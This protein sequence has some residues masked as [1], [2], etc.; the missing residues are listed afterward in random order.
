MGFAA[1]A[2]ITGNFVI[3]AKRVGIDASNHF[4]HLAG[5]HLGMLFITGEIAR[6][7]AIHA[8]EARARDECAHYR[9]NFFGGDYLQ[10]LR[11]CH[12]RAPSATAARRG[13]LLGKQGK[14]TDRD[15]GHKNFAH[16]PMS[17]TWP[18]PPAM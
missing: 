15:D 14:S 3:S 2:R 4:K 8:F 10:V 16:M 7:V 5:H 9:A 13:R 17:V 18:E 12:A 11:R 1:M 6:Y